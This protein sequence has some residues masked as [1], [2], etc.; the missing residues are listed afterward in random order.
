MPKNYQIKFIC[1]TKVIPKL[2]SPEV[3]SFSFAIV[4]QIA[5]SLLHAQQY[6]G[7]DERKKKRTT[8]HT[9]QSTLNFRAPICCF[10][11]RIISIQRTLKVRTYFLYSK[12]KEKKQE[13]DLV[14]NRMWVAIIRQINIS[15]F[16]CIKRIIFFQ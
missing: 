10:G 7:A 13:N 9:R 16:I 14:P 15:F 5:Q 11:N 6:C 2:H 3:F 4:F 12:K 1:T 8:R